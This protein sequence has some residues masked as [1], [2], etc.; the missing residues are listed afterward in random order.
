MAMQSG[1]VI[2]PFYA[3]V[4]WRDTLQSSDK[5][6]LSADCLIKLQ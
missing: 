4:N 1:V 2:A 3:S 5:I 6:E